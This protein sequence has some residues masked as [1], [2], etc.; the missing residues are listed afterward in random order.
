MGILRKKGLRPIST[1][2]I[3]FRRNQLKSKTSSTANQLFLRPPYHLMSVKS[4]TEAQLAVLKP[5]STKSTRTRY[6]GKINA[7]REKDKQKCNPQ[8]FP[9]PC[10]GLACWTKPERHWQGKEARSGGCQTQPVEP[11]SKS[12]IQTG[13]AVFATQLQEPAGAGRAVPR[14][15]ATAGAACGPGA[16]VGDRPG[17]PQP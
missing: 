15:R 2:V 13:D 17:S 9:G 16:P 8:V 14:W 5:K 10:T 7:G 12:Q 6:S 4:P 1:K 3:Q 11:G